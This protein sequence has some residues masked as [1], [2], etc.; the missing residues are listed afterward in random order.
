M[1][2]TLT[3]GL[4]EL[5]PTLRLVYAAENESRSS[6][7]DIVGQDDGP[8]VSLAADAPRTGTIDLFWSA[9]AD[10]EAARVAL[11][12]PGVWTL[13]DDVDLVSMTFVRRGRMSIEQQDARLRW[14]LRVG[15][16]E[17]A[18]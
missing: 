7:H 4:T 3:K 1:A 5:T 13:A 6:F 14:V 15:F 12:A 18:A 11:L 2:V 9:A 10:A 16:Q 8:D 17:V